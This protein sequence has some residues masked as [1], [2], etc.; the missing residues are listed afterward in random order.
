[1]HS[2]ALNTFY[3][4]LHQFYMRL[5]TFYIGFYVF[6]FVVM[7]LE[8]AFRRIK[9]AKNRHILPW[10]FFTSPFWCA[11]LCLYGLWPIWAKPIW[12]KPIWAKPIWAK[13]IWA[14]PMW[15]LAHMGP[16]PDRAGPGP[17]EVKVPPLL[18]QASAGPPPGPLTQPILG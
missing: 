16:G 6:A 4:R 2:N 8:A 14:K 13:P 10:Q 12:A 18:P 3:M 9:S 7:R 5:N 1:M 15:A 17:A 11:L